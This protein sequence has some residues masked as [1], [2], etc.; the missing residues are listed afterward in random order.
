MLAQRFNAGVQTGGVEDAGGDHLHVTAELLTRA[1]G[2]LYH[3][4]AVEVTM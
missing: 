1:G 3:L 2:Q 4:G